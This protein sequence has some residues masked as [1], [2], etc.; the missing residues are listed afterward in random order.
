[1]KEKIRK[2]LEWIASKFRKATETAPESSV[3]LYDLFEK[4]KVALKKMD[5]GN[6]EVADTTPEPPQEANDRPTTV[7]GWLET[8]PDGYKELA[9]KNKYETVFDAESDSLSN[10]L[11]RAFC[12]REAPEGFAFWNGVSNWIGS[13]GELPS[14]PQSLPNDPNDSKFRIV[15]KD[16]MKA[17][18]DNVSPLDDIGDTTRDAITSAFIDM[19]RASLRAGRA[20][21]ASTSIP[22][23]SK[24]ILEQE[25]Q[26]CIATEN[27]E[28]CAEIKVLLDKLNKVND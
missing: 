22:S 19:T 11:D 26:S 2:V 6:G 24:E 14:L 17:R 28:R 13:N 18:L 8:L 10:A 4:M 5:D 16:E 1:M 15:P 25:L 12:W 3:T 20:A 23:F 21:L 27:Y 7:I 9:I